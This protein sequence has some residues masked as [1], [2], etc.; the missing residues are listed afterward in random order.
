M[1]RISQNIKRTAR[2]GCVGDEARLR[3]FGYVQRRDSEYI[4]RGIPIL[5]LPGRR[6]VGRSKRRFMDGVKEDEKLVGVREDDQ[7]GRFDGGR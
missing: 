7:R 5:Q 4:S 3:W 1:D 2:V 6:S